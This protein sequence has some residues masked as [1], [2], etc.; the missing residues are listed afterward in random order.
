MAQQEETR[1]ILL[2]YVCIFVTIVCTFVNI[3]LLGPD[4]YALEQGRLVLLSMEPDLIRF[5]DNSG[6]DPLLFCIICTQQTSAASPVT[7]RWLVTGGQNPISVSMVVTLLKCLPRPHIHSQAMCH[8]SSLQGMGLA[9]AASLGS[10]DSLA[11]PGPHPGESKH[12]PD[13]AGSFPMRLC[14]P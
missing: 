1:R 4:T 11:L 14:G 6:S 8:P 9:A 12:G 10:Q 5:I 13:T 2:H 7:P 3:V